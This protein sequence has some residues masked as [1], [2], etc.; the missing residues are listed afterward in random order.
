MSFQFDDN[1]IISFI[2]YEYQINNQINLSNLYNYLDEELN[3]NILE[4]L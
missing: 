2:I 1:K 4:V 3:N